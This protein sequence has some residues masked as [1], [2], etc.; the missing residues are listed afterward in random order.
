MGST[1]ERGSEVLLVSA[2]E[3]AAGRIGRGCPWPA[4]S[5]RGAWNRQFFSPRLSVS[6][7]AVASLP[8][9][10]SPAPARSCDHRRHSLGP[11]EILR[12]VL[13]LAFVVWLAPAA[14]A[15]ALQLALALASNGGVWRRALEVPF[16]QRR[17]STL[18]ARDL[19]AGRAR[20]YLNGIIDA[21]LR[22]VP[23]H[24]T[25][26]AAGLASRQQAEALVPVPYLCFP[27]RLERAPN[28][29]WNGW[30][31]LERS[32]LLTLDEELD[33]R[34]AGRKLVLASGPGWK[35]WQ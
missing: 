4:G 31:A 20:G 10:R 14:V 11:H 24:E 6:K 3:I 2:N 16:D 34:L 13:T 21:I 29:P 5:P 33:A 15:A 17:R 28:D 32:V 23:E 27:R 1:W 26:H 12:T 22:H 30:E 18:D 35:L 8:S 9:S 19:E 7:L 25:V